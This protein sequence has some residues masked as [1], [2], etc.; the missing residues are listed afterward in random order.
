[1]VLRQICDFDRF[2]ENNRIK[3]DLE[4]EFI[5]FISDLERKVD[6]LK[7]SSEIFI[8]RASL[9]TLKNNIFKERTEIKELVSRVDAKFYFVYALQGKG[10]IDGFVM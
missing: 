6:S 7:G 8:V 4:N 5:E 3:P 9:S 2:I 1:M 10:E